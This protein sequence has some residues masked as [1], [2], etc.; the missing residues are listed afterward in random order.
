MLADPVQHPGNGGSHR[1]LAAAADGE[2]AH[3]DHRTPQP[4]SEIRPPRI[5]LAPAARH[6]RIHRTQHVTQIRDTHRYS[7]L[8]GRTVP[9]VSDG[10]SWRDHGQALRAR[11][12]IGLD[13]RPRGGA[14]AGALD[15][16]R[17]QLH[18]RRLELGGRADLDRAAVVDE[19]PGDVR[20]VVHVRPEHDRLAEHRGL[21]DVVPSRIDQAA[22]DEDHGG[23][24]IH[25]RQLADRVEHHDVDAGLGV[26]RQLG[27]PRDPPAAAPREPLDLVESFGLPRRDDQQRVA[28]G[29]A[30]ALKGVEDRLLLSFERRRRD[31]HRAA[32][33]DPEVAEDAVAPAVGAGRA[34]NLERIELERAGDRHARAIGADLDD[35][36]GRFLALHAEAIDVGE[37]A[38]EERAGQPVAGKGTGRDAAVDEHGLH[39]G[40]VTHAQEVRPDLGLHDDE[41]ARLHQPERPL[42]D[43]T[44]IE[45]EVEHLV[46]VVDVPAR[47]LLP[48][49]RRRG[50]EDAKPGIALAQLRQQRPRG[51]HLADRHRVDPDRLVAVEVERQR[52]V[53]EPLRQAADVLAVTDRL[54]EEVRRHDQ[55]EQHD[56]D[57]VQRVHGR[58]PL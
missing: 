50:Q 48:G 7:T 46:H 40:L 43:R 27:P 36:A 51:Q 5:A 28:P 16:V 24:L 58:S 41:Q 31:D 35:A 12:A 25:L 42:H 4:A 57:A 2:I 14:H 17:Q 21:E 52:Q 33:G 29:G 34:G 23:H 15:R 11:A 49:H 6:G 55:E 53:A 22:A 9:G 39:P 8:K 20:E 26:D 38:P 30:H 54:V 3:A 45:R 37:H 47:H 10:I 18:E 32:A 44:E 1:G 19:R 13:Q 56:Q